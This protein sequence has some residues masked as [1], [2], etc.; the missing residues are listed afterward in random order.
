MLKVENYTFDTQCNNF[1]WY[2]WEIK[3]KIVDCYCND[4]IN[5]ASL[6]CCADVNPWIGN[7]V[8]CHYKRKL[9]ACVWMS[10]AIILLLRSSFF[11]NCQHR[12]YSNSRGHLGFYYNGD[13]EFKSQIFKPILWY[14]SFFCVGTLFIFCVSLKSRWSRHTINI[15]WRVRWFL[16]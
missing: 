15:Q 7:L 2:T 11:S 13:D 14:I 10:N 4:K 16:L 6:T 9:P 12:H 5:Y 1:L 3:I 8:N